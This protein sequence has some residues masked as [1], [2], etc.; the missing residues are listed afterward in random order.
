MP[1]PLV[2]GATQL[3]S[4]A[5]NPEKILNGLFVAPVGLF[6]EPAQVIQ[7]QLWLDSWE[8]RQRVSWY[9]LRWTIQEAIGEQLSSEASFFYRRGVLF[10]LEGNI[11]AAKERFKDSLRKPP[12]GWDLPNL[13]SA[14]ADMYLKL[15]ERAEKGAP[16]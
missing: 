12:P 16:R 6:P 14:E 8:N 9:R 11:P 7:M 10:L 15:I 4:R 2:L 1:K 3:I 5:Q 13:Q